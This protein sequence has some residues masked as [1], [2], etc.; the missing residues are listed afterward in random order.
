MAQKINGSQIGGYAFKARR[1][2]NL[3]SGT[4][5]A[6]DVVFDQEYYDYGNWYNPATGLATA[7]IS[8]IYHFTANA[9]TQTT[10]TARA[11]FTSRGTGTSGTHPNGTSKTVERARDG[12]ASAVNRIE[13]NYEVYLAA[14]DTYGVSLWTSASNQL[15][16]NDT[17]FA[18][19]LVMAV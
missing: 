3:S 7:P 5:A 11:F 19:H 14:G 10:T 18:G 4:N 17:W 1:A 6:V 15:N 16:N 2:T 12:S 8:G 13:A 9:F